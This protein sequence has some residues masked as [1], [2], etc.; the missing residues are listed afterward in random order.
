MTRPNILLITSDQQRYDAVGAHGSPFLTTP[1]LDSLAHEGVTFQRTYCPNAVC[2]P[3]RLSL[4]TGTFLSRHGGYNIGC[5]AI[6]KTRFLS[7]MLRAA[8]YRTHHIGK[9]HWHPWNDSSPEKAPVDEHGTPWRDFVGFD[10]AELTTGH[11][12]WGVTGHYA[13]WLER[14]GIPRRE[15]NQITPLFAQDPNETGT[16]GMPSANHSSAW[17]AE[18]TTDFLERHDHRQPF[19]LNLG[20]QDPHHP[21]AVPFDFEARV[22]QDQLPGTI[23]SETDTDVPEPVQ[24]LR[25]GHIN[26]SRYRGPFEIAGN[27]GTHDWQAY[28]SDPARERAT[29]AHYYSL[30]NLIDQQLGIILNALKALEYE[31]DTIVVFTSDHGDML[32]DHDIGQKG[33][34]A[35]ESVLRVPLLLRYPGHVE[36]RALEHP[37]S[38]V[39]VYPTLLG[40]A[41]VPCP[42][43]DGIDL[44]SYLHGG[45]APSRPGVRVEYKEEPDRLRYKAWITTHYKLVVYPGESFGELYDLNRDPHEHSN[46]FHDP[47]FSAIKAQLLTQLLEDLERSEPASERPSR[48]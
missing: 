10:T 18:R 42:R 5:T 46:R 24:L 25:S 35:Y 41:G 3:S 44:R 23:S 9:A 22:D 31:R 28:F 16:W 38:L 4:M 33:P 39:D 27:S 7:V 15:L 20:F 43:V 45:P 37:V 19:F 12:T 36:L 13:R 32:G 6:D 40:Y 30:V 11:V 8:G 14:R 26:S 1:H 21:H 47:D 2:T 29:R 34:L 17:I 48:V